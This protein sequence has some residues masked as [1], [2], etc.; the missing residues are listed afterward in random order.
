MPLV[1]GHRGRVCRRS[2]GNFNWETAHPPNPH[3]RSDWSMANMRGIFMI[4][5]WCERAQLIVGGATLAYKKAGLSKTWGGS[6]EEAYLHGLCTGSSRLQSW[7]FTLTSLG[8]GL[9]AISPSKPFPS[10]VTFGHG[11]LSQKTNKQTN[12]QTNSGWVNGDDHFCFWLGLEIVT[13]NPG[14]WTGSRN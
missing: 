5:D 10:Q 12:K 2:R 11:V 8:N 14:E 3:P 6:Q 4:D 1:L 9:Q 13:K 7:V